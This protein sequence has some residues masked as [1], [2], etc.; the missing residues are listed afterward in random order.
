MKLRST[1]TRRFSHRRNRGG[2]LA[3]ANVTQVNRAAVS[4]RSPDELYKQG[5]KLREKC[6]RESHAAWK[7]PANRPDPIALLEESSKGRL[8]ELIPIRYGRMMQSPFTF[9]RGAALN[10][11]DDL[12]HTPASGLRVQ[13][14]GDAHLLNFG[15]YATPERREIFDINDLDE[16]LP[17]PWEWDV[18]RLSASFVLACRN[19]GFSDDIA[20]DTVQA[21]VR[22][23]RRCMAEFSE[24]PVLDVWYSRTELKD[25]IALIE[26]PEKLKQT[27]KQL[28]KAEHGSKLEHHFPKLTMMIEDLPVIK[29]SPPLIYHFAEEAHKEFF[30]KAHKTFLNYRHSLED[31]RRLLL[32]RFQVR[33][34]AIKVVGI[35]SVGTFCAIALLLAGEQDALFLQIKEAGPSVLERYAGKSIYSNHGQRVV[36]G[37]RRMQAASDLFLGWTDGWQGRHFYIRQLKDMKVKPMVEVFKKNTMAEYAKLC[38]LVL[39]R[40]HARSGQPALI[41]GYLGRSDKFDQAIADFSIAYADQSELDHALL[42]SAVRKSRLHAV[43]GGNSGSSESHSSTPARPALPTR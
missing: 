23:Y 26:D 7:A 16:T 9:Y 12:S 11:A 24:M 13:A 15:A 34:I 1:P 31:D 5:K 3:Q 25:L 4:L 43:M 8:P 2:R 17:A 37:A 6:P 40:A 21:C 18:K 27:T 42:L 14:C 29:D 36:T 33:D 19:N 35:G 38:G 39:A 10:M 28:A 32:D 41:S 22:S 20:R 30:A